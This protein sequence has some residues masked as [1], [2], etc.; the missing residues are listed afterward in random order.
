[1]V[2]GAGFIGSHLVDRLLAEDR[3][4]T[5][6]T[7]CRRGASPTSPTRA[8]GRRR[9]ED[10]PP[11]RVR[12]EFAAL[13]GDAPARRRLPPRAGCRRARCGRLPRGRRADATLA[14]LEAA[15]ATRHPE[16]RRRLPG[17]AL[18]GDVPR[19]TCRSRRAVPGT[20]SA[21]AASSREAIVDLLGHV[22][23]AARRRV[24]GP[25]HVDGLRATAAPRRRCGRGRSQRA[26]LNAVGAARS[27][28]T[29]ARHATSLFVDDA[30]DALVRAGEPG[31]R[32]RR[33]HRHRHADVDPR[34]VGARSPERPR[35]GRSV[36][37][38]GGRRA[39]ALRAVTG[40]GPDPPRVGAV[41]RPRTSGLA[42]CAERTARA[43]TARQGGSRRDRRRRRASSSPTASPRI[44]SRPLRPPRRGAASAGSITSVAAIG[45]VQPGD[46]D[47]RR[48]V[49]ELG[50]HPVG[51]SLQRRTADDRR[52]GDDRLAPRR[53]AARRRR[54]ARGSGRSTR[55]G[56]TARSR[57]R[58]PRR[59]RRAAGADS[60]RRRAV[61]PH[62]PDGDTSGAAARSTPGTTISPPS[63][64][65]TIVRHPVVGHRHQPL[66][67]APAPR[68]LG[69]HLGERGALGRGAPS[70]R[71]GSP[72]R[73]RR[74]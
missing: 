41:D 5:S 54:R 27:T 55:S 53:R 14:L 33:Q 39:L 20:A 22:P 69:G 73:G 30:V 49:A 60:A 18:Y 64:S 21:C 25:R 43:L 6:S 32:P 11:R 23:R 42:H 71:S 47:H 38:T 36:G 45:R 16:G 70:G 66:G 67:D 4:S 12:R 28:A 72:G 37:A 74:G 65:V 44:A 46:A 1:M 58:R 15:R 29:A 62:G 51:R 9:A 50:Q 61:E 8:V 48:L 40:P 34:P 19:A 13:V 35:P 68:D 2:G 59:A 63:A 52:H 26:A 10:P 7:T 31:R 57:P 56:S 3:R 24:H 17:G